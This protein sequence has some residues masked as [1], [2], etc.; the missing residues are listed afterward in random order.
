M[1]S[2]IANDVKGGE[3]YTWTWTQNKCKR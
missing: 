2:I 3:N 1:Q